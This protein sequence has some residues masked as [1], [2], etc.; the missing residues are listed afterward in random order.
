[1]KSF[2]WHEVVALAVAQK[3]QPAVYVSNSLDFNDPQDFEIWKFVKEQCKELF[4]DGS[5]KFYIAMTAMVGSSLFFFDTVEEQYAFY[6]IFEHPAID[7]SGIYAC[8][9]RADGVC[10]TENT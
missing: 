5:E 7:S 9:Y 3:G 8:T 1:M 2:Q 4:V 10:L 6:R